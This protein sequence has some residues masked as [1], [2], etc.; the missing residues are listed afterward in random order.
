MPTIQKRADA[1]TR[2]RYDKM[3]PRQQGYVWY[4]QEAWNKNIPHKSPYRADSKE[5]EQWLKGAD[6]GYWDTMDGDDE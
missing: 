5:Y 1:I 3:T 4:M 2:E 6:A